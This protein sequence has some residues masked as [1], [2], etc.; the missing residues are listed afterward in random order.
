MMRYK[1]ASGGTAVQ[2]LQDG[3]LDLQKAKIIQVT[4]HGG[5]GATACDKDVP[6]FLAVGKQV[7]VTLALANLFI[8]Q[9][10]ILLR[11]RTQPL[12]KDT[13]HQDVQGALPSARGKE[14]T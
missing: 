1:W 6:G 4:A 14:K 10:M 7:K 2:W 5:N 8:F 9:P 11:E 13:I 3:R 12:G